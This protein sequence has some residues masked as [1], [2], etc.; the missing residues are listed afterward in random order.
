MPQPTAAPP[1]Q[2]AQHAHA[3]I[4]IALARTQ[5]GATGRLDFDARLAVGHLCAMGPGAWGH[6]QGLV[7]AAPG[8]QQAQAVLLIGMQAAAL[9]VKP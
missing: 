7:D 8:P 2:H 4:Q 9:Q 3:G 1:A 6:L 5:A